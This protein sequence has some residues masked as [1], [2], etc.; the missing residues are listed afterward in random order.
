MGGAKFLGRD[1]GMP[2]TKERMALEIFSF[3]MLLG[4]IVS[5]VISILFIHNSNLFTPIGIYLFVGVLL[6]CN[7]LRTDKI[8][9][10]KKCQS[11]SELNNTGG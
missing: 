3:W 7:Y 11:F 8:D 2:Y 10:K 1:E 9:R 6:F 4:W 5:L